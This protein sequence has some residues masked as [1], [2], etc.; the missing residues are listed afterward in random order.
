M[1]KENLRIY[2][3]HPDGKCSKESCLVCYPEN[4]NDFKGLSRSSSERGLTNQSMIRI[5]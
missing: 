2:L 3:T 1:K 5:K 4:I